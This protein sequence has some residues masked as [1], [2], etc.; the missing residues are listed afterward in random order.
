MVGVC[1]QIMRPGYFS[2][3]IFFAIRLGLDGQAN[4]FT[5]GH[6]L[7]QWW[8]KNIKIN[9]DSGFKTNFYT[10]ATLQNYADG[11]ST[12]LVSLS[13]GLERTYFGTNVCPWKDNC[14]APYY[15]MYDDDWDK[16]NYLV[17]RTNYF[18]SY[19]F[20]EIYK[21]N[22]KYLPST[23]FVFHG[24]IN[25]QPTIFITPAYDTLYV[26]FTNV[27]NSDQNYKVDPTNLKTFFPSAAYV[28]L[29]LATVTYIQADQLYSTSGKSS[30]Y[31]TLLNYCYK[32]FNHPIEIQAN[33]ETT[34]YPAIITA[35]NLPQ[36]AVEGNVNG[37]L[38][39]PSYTI[40]YF[41]IPLYPIEDP[42]KQLDRKEALLNMNIYPN[43][44]ST[45]FSVKPVYQVT[46]NQY[47]NFDI[48]VLSMQGKLMLNTVADEHAQI[49]ISQLPAGCYQIIITDE[50][51]YHYYKKLIKTE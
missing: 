42:Y 36:C 32:T 23:F 17:R 41:K 10:Y 20:G 12:D 24:N 33:S 22:L 26:Y 16:R 1:S 30:L 37:C 39:A 28:D 50:N 7:L 43:P 2:L 25:I 11:S 51:K 14:T 3:K 40:G 6:L 27:K 48:E 47:Q 9:F 45:A 15:C 21:K 29:G 44:T 46:N 34:L 38:T 4:G 49:N 35:S 8:L 31:D 18:V 5:H 13:D 19:L